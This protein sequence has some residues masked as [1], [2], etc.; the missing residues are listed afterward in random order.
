MVWATSYDSRTRLVII[1]DTLTARPYFDE[2]LRPVLLSFLS[3]NPGLT[4]Q[5]DNARPHTARLSTNAHFKRSRM[6]SDE[7]TFTT[8][9]GLLLSNSSNGTCMAGNPAGGHSQTLRVNA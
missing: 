8:V 4:F 5:Q 1:R 2:I 3:R 7:Q 6:Y 9:C